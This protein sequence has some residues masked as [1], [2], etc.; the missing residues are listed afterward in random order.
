MTHLKNLN[1]HLNPNFLFRMRENFAKLG[2]TG[3]QVIVGGDSA[4][5]SIS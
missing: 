4:G 3:A 1:Q 5:S 2:T